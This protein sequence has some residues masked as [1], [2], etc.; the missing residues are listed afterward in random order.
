MENLVFSL[1]ATI[2]IFLMM[3]LGYFLHNKTKALDDVFA[4]KMNDFVFKVSLPI[5]LFKNLA[6]SDFHSVWDG[7]IVIFCFGISL[8]S[9][10]LTVGASFLLKKKDL[11][12]EFAQA[13][14]R[15]S[16]ALLGVAFLEN[17]YGSSGP[18]ALVLI[19]SV[20][21]YNVAA[22]VILTLMAPGGHL[23]RSTFMKTLRG[24]LTNPLILG[25]VAG[26]I[27]SI[28]R[29]PQPAIFQRTVSNLAST[30]T[31]LGLMALG[32]SIDPR[33]AMDSLSL[34][35]VCSAFKLIFFVAVFLPPAILIGCR[36]QLLVAILVMLGSPT[37]VSCFSMAVSMGHEGVLSSSTVVVTT[38]LSSFTFTAW[39]F[40]LKT[41]ALI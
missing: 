26:L 25:I 10:L 8:A 41:L 28:L 19:G 38:I 9:I 27:W 12:A 11:R 29:I 16:M 13:S 40:L 1:N 14:Y 18:M 2:P 32:A 5:Q 3:L 24:I 34:A 33:K 31:P 37:T 36:G 21:L 22:V 30:A 15:S 17:M 35:M 23:D 6:D 4:K 7:K 20:P 39:L